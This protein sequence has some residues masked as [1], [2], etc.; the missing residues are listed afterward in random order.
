MNMKT[1]MLAVS[2][3]LLAA[4]QASSQTKTNMEQTKTIRLVYP[5][6]QGGKIEQWIIWQ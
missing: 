6:W 4:E 5:Q 3:S 1:L 2:L